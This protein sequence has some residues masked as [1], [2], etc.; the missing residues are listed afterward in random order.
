[1]VQ[2]FEKARKLW[3]GAGPARNEQLVNLAED[4]FDALMVSWSAA[5]ARLITSDITAVLKL[6]RMTILPNFLYNPF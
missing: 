2:W 1:M 3:V 4:F 5:T 6:D